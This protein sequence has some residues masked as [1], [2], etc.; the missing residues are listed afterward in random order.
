MRGLA[1]ALHPRA[2][3]PLVTLPRPA[4]PPSASLPVDLSAQP[5]T[6]HH[7]AATYLALS[8]I[9]ARTH[10]LTRLLQCS[11]TLPLQPARALL[12]P[13]TTCATK[14]P[15]ARRA[16]PNNLYP[17]R[18]APEQRHPPSGY[19]STDYTITTLDHRSAINHNH[20]HPRKTRTLHST[21]LT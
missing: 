16:Y 5:T 7:S 12:S 8:I 11:L 19:S 10:V 3:H 4:P 21:R 20:L 1:S 13:Q 14:S 17:S 9:T 2:V 15:T 6:A 18:S